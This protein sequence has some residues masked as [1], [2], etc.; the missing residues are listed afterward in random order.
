MPRTVRA[1]LVVV[2]LASVLGAPGAAQ[3]KAAAPGQEL[4]RGSVIERVACAG[5]P[6]QSYALYLPSGYTRDRA[7][8]I[9]YAFDPGGQGARPVKLAAAAGH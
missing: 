7:W 6:G 3:D 1:R 9:L 5:V 4:P 8:P 2:A